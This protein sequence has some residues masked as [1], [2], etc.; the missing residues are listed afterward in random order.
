M[1]VCSDNLLTRLILKLVECSHFLFE[2]H[3]SR[4]AAISSAVNPVYLLCNA[5]NP[6]YL[7]CKEWR[8]KNISTTPQTVKLMLFQKAYWMQFTK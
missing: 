6:V 1:R 3:C 2:K 4:E 8:S 7:L 5:V